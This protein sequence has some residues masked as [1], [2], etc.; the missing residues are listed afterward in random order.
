MAKKDEADKP[1]ALRLDRHYDAAPEEVWRAWT[2]PEEMKR[3]WGPGRN[4]VVHLAEADV[5]VGGSFRVAFTSDS[6]EMLEVSG[7]YSEIVPH[8]KLAFTWAWKSAP[9]QE[10]RVT[11]TFEPSGGGTDLTLLHEQF[12]DAGAR[13][14]HEEGWSNALAKIDAVIAR[15]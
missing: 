15:H 12:F 6:D 14:A 2:E 3:W 8:R 7:V 11:V 1:P 4:D 13:D 10:S 9:E 5:R